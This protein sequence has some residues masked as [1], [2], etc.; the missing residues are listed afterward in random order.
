MFIDSLNRDD[1]YQLY[2][3]L[4]GDDSLAGDLAPCDII[5]AL[6]DRMEDAESEALAH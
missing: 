2:A 6:L 4:T 3:T 5:E 1:A